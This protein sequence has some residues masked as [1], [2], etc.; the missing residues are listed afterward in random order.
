MPEQTKLQVI[1]C[2]HMH[3]PEYRD[4]RNGSYQFP[5]TYLHA[6]KDYVDMAAHLEAEPAARAVVNFA[7]VLL[8]QIADY[9]SQLEAWMNRG[10]ALRDPLL[11][12]LADP[13]VPADPDLRRALMRQCLRA[14]EKRIIQRFPAYR[15]LA[16]MAG[17]IDKNPGSQ[18]Y[19]ADQFLIDLL[20]WYHLGWMAETVRRGDKR[21]RQLQDRGQGFTVHE[22]RE[23]LQVILEQLQSV[24]PR[25]SRLAKQG[26][27]ELAMSPYAHPI[28]PLLIDLTAGQQAQPDGLRPGVDV[29]PGGRER[30]RWHLRHGRDVF[31][32]H[33]GIRPGGCWPSEG[34]LSTETIGLLAEEGFMWTASGAN[35]LHNSI[36]AGGE[37]QP[38]GTGSGCRH[39]VYRVAD[40]PIACFFRDDGLS[41]LIGFEYSGW[42]AEDAVANLVHHMEN[43]ADS[44]PDCRNCAIAVI[45]DGENAWEYYPENAYHFLG[46]LYRELSR[47]ARLKLGTFSEFLENNRPQPLQL[48]ALVA[49]SWVHGTLSTWVGSADKNRGWEMLVDAKRCYDSV[50]AAGALDPEQLERARMQL[51]VCEGSDWFWWFGDYNPAQSVSDFERLFRQ[52]L[53][54]LYHVLGVEPPAYLSE[55]FTHGSGTPERGGVMRTASD[56]PA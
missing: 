10:T 9:A 24:I 39:R 55:S 12:A 41:D 44:C 52:H 36:G 23:L 5:W 27:V 43:I 46:A 22:R 15:R 4:L 48:P 17:W 3:Q 14:N 51:A 26:R 20:V 42:H 25:F 7:P 21:V 11:A 1:L 18:L 47:H 28:L 31:E 45:L 2:W 30:A 6:L 50:V 33:F 34:A 13:P 8:D 49:G 16:D 54:N 37:P 19:V 29:Y 32:R 35:V 56:K 53:A 38:H 40:Q